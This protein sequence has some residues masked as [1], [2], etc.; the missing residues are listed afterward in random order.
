[1]EITINNIIFFASEQVQEDATANVQNN[2]K[3]LQQTVRNVPQQVLK[4][5][6]AF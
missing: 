4:L 2:V 1:M 6:I 3:S 5:K